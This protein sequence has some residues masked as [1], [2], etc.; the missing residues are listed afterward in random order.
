MINLDFYKAGDGT[1]QNWCNVL[2]IWHFHPVISIGYWISIL[3]VFFASG[4][5]GSPRKPMST[6]WGKES[7]MRKYH[8]HGGSSLVLVSTLAVSRGLDGP[9][10]TNMNQT[11]IMW[12]SVSNMYENQDHHSRFSRS[13]RHE[14]GMKWL[15]DLTKYHATTCS[16]ATYKPMIHTLHT[17]H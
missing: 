15:P 3:L 1:K 2:F 14:L 8:L 11:T 7:W 4:V 17:F 5:K 13:P 16:I 12:V 9:H 10:A 6:Q